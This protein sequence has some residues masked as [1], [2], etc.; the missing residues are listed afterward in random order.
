MTPAEKLARFL[1]ER[2]ARDLAEANEYAERKIREDKITTRD[3]GDL[4]IASRPLK[5][6]T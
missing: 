4:D 6:G 2:H 5:P 1:E 3:C